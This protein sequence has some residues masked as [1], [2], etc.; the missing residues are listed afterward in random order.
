MLKK[1]KIQKQNTKYKKYTK[2]YT[3][4]NTQKNTKLK[5]GKKIKIHKK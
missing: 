4:E 5:V 2:K 1:N 3:K